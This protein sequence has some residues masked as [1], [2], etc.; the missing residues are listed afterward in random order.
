MFEL[1][2]HMHLACF[3]TLNVQRLH[4]DIDDDG[5]NYTTSNEVLLCLING[6]FI[7]AMQIAVVYCIIIFIVVIFYSLAKS[8][9]LRYLAFSHS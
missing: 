6:F 2:V 8:L 1:L 9:N 3:V 7:S 5:M 4:D